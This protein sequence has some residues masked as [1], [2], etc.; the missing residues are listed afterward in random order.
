MF[1]KMN[2]LMCICCI[3]VWIFGYRGIWKIQLGSLVRTTPLSSVSAFRLRRLKLV[4]NFSY[5][6]LQ[7]IKMQHAIYS[8]YDYVKMLSFFS[9]YTA[10]T[11]NWEAGLNISLLLFDYRIGVKRIVK[12]LLF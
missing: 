10:C 3:N 6:F 1:F 7:S 12:Y 11:F 8:N 4:Q 9:S 5:R 2:T